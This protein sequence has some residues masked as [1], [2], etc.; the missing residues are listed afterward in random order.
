MVC[1]HPHAHVHGSPDEELKRRSL[2]ILLAAACNG[3][4]AIAEWLAF[5]WTQSMP[6]NA[7]YL[8]DAAD[9]GECLVFLLLMKGA[10]KAP[11]L[12]KVAEI[13]GG[14][15]MAYASGKA[16]MHGLEHMKN[17][18]TVKTDLLMVL[19]VFNFCVNAGMAVI[20]N[21][22]STDLEKIWSLH[23]IQDAAISAAMLLAWGV[24]FII[25]PR[26]AALLDA[27]IAWEI[28]GALFLVAVW[29]TGAILI[30]A[31]KPAAA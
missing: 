23:F 7:A 24:S 8:H 19:A 12:E 27:F 30:K 20:L 1:A 6:L 21:K 28:S 3:I 14:L 18:Q 4:L 10:Q 29:R 16:F 17:P 31:F 15:L 11:Y 5:E 13:A 25:N 9:F 2:N 26:D 22:G